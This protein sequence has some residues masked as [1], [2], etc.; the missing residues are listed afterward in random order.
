MMKPEYITKGTEVATAAGYEIITGW[1]GHIVY[2]DSYEVDEDGNESKVCERML[3]LEEIG[4]LM[5]EVDGKNH[6]VVWKQ[7]PEYTEWYAVQ[8]DSDD[9]DW[10]T[11]SFNYDEALEMAYKRGCKYIATIQGE[12]DENGDPITCGECIL[13]EEVE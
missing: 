7:H 4:H 3:T 1:N 12:W 8:R 9:N 2:T 13:V 11:G 10:G 5:K 6:K